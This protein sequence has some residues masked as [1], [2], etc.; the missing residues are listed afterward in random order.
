MNYEQTKNS[1]LSIKLFFSNLLVNTVFDAFLFQLQLQFYSIH[2]NCGH[3]NIIPQL[4]LKTEFY[5]IFV[6]SQSIV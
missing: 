3:K 1:F 5:P 6:R 4:N 2:P